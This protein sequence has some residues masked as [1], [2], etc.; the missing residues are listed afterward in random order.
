VTRA[1][2]GVPVSPPRSEERRSV[3]VGAAV[4]AAA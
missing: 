1:P 3:E 2:V 4:D